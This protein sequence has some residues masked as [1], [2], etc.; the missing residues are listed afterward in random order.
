MLL[1][2]FSVLR[3][4]DSMYVIK[5]KKP[6][7]SLYV[8][9]SDSF[10]IK[11]E[12]YLFTIDIENGKKK[13][14]SVSSDSI[15]VSRVNGNKYLIKVPRKSRI[16]VG[17]INVQVRNED[18]SVELY[19]VLTYR[20]LEPIMPEI[21]VG[22]IKADSLIDKRYLYDYAQLKAFYK[23]VPVQILSF[24]FCTYQASEMV[25]LHSPN[26]KLTLGMKQYIQRMPP[27]SM[28]YFRNIVCLLPNGKTET[29]DSI[30]LFFDVTNKYKVGERILYRN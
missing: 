23:G 26:S 3:G 8:S 11:G 5:I 30:R 24:D 21:F 13:I 19:E 17:A 12:A 28:I 2:C 27:G 20:I 6:S 25:T 10:L 29:V 14:A 22:N 1:L 18:G 4:Q 15:Y 9:Y 7:S 16:G